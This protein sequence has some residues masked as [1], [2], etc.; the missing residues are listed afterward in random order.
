MKIKDV[1]CI[2]VDSFR[3]NWVFAVVTLEDGTRGLGESTLIGTEPAVAAMIDLWGQRLIGQSV[4]DACPIQAR[5]QRE[6]YWLTGPVMS[7]AISALDTAIWDAKARVLGVPLYV[8]LGGKARPSVPVYANGWF[9]GAKTPA[10]FAE[11]A[12]RVV[13]QGFRA[14]KWDPFGS[15]FRSMDREAINRAIECVAEVRNAVGRNVDLMIEAHGRFDL[16]T[17]IEVGRALEE[18]SISWLEEPLPPG[19][20]FE[21]ADLRRA[22]N[23]PI[24]AG[25]RC[26]SRFDVMNLVRAGA[27]DVL[28]PDVAHIGGLTEMV[29]VNGIAES[30]S[31]PYSPHNPNGP[32]CNLASIHAGLAWEGVSWLETMVTDV[33]WRRQ[34]VD[35]GCRLED[36][37]LWI[38][39]RPGLGLD[40][41]FEIARKY[42]YKQHQLRHYSGKLTNIRPP[43]AVAWYDVPADASLAAAQ[44]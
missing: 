14:I 18:F 3:T 44:V 41:D 19:R 5:I 9:I 33:P 36:G 34:I 22:V 27:V 23:V 12:R 42:P 17:G 30:C 31:L 2:T 7:A 15:N 37:A 8:L 6:S 38:E 43:D 32:V 35:E 26:F 4:M 10:E 1:S 29:H 20:P 24:A 11:K 13:D 21:L 39:D 28:Q 16:N 25:E 40:L